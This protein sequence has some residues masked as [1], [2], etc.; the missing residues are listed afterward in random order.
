MET[1]RQLGL[2]FGGSEAVRGV[3]SRS[4]ASWVSGFAATANGLQMPASLLAV[5]L[6]GA[7]RACGRR[8]DGLLGADFLE[9][10]VV[11][12]DYKAGK[13]RLLDR[14]SATMAGGSS[15]P[16]RR[17]NDGFGVPVSVCGNKAEWM[18]LDTGC[19][20]ALHW[21]ISKRDRLQNSHMVS[22]GLSPASR[23]LAKADVCLGTD[24]LHNVTIGFQE[25]EIFPGESGLLGNGLLSRYRVTIDTA[26]NR[27]LL[28]KS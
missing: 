8:I 9:G 28:E 16:L 18:R 7:S 4:T 25:R 19:D 1:A 27:V 6:G 24:C 3:N 23:N 21:V 15:L 13:I 17:L 14:A 5:D 26:K 22:I 20:A 2:K 12:I 10:R 11:Q